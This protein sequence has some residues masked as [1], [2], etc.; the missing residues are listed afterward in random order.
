DL[1]VRRLLS[2]AASGPRCGVFT[3]IH[4]DQRKPAPPEFVP[5]DLRKA[6]VRVGS[7]G[8]RFGLA[9]KPLE[10][11]TLVLDPP[12]DPDLATALLANVG[13]CSVGFNRVEMPFWEI[14]AKD[15]A[16]W[17]GDGGAEMQVGIG[18][19]RAS[20]LHQLVRGR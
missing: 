8:G 15:S 7:R 14:A 11:T 4:W 2:I 19:C 13:R 6:S 1:A 3:F 10:G 18:R 9:D 5:D 17:S 16:L 20:K 12:P